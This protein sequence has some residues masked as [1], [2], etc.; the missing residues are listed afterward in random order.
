MQRIQLRWKISEKNAFAVWSR[1][2][3]KWFDKLSAAISSEAST[4]EGR[5]GLF[6]FHG[7]MASHA[8]TVPAAASV[9]GI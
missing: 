6:G 9:S 2:L 8:T 1:V 3:H 4:E 5:V 7:W